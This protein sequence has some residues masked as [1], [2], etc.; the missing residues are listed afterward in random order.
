MTTRDSKEAQI[1]SEGNKERIAKEKLKRI[2]IKTML[3][4]ETEIEKEEKITKFNVV[5]KI[6]VVFNIF[7]MKHFF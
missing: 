1:V 6:I 3:E 2:T 4:K 5:Q 7:M